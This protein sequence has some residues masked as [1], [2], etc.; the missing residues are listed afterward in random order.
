M[1]QDGRMPLKRGTTWFSITNRRQNENFPNKELTQL[2]YVHGEYFP[3][4]V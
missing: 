1:A 4:A 2:K 3:L